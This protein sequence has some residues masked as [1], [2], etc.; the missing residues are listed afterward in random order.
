MRSA[1]EYIKYALHAVAAMRTRAF[2]VF[3]ANTIA[4]GSVIVLSSIGEG[5]RAFVVN[6]F[7]AL[8]TNLLIV[9][10]GR[11]ETSGEGLNM[12]MGSTPRD[13]TLEDAEAIARHPAVTQIAPMTVGTTTVSWRS[14]E[15]DVPIIGS[16]S[17]LSSIRNWNVRIGE[18]LPQQSD[19]QAV[20]IAVLGAKTK[21]ELF[22][23]ESAL[24]QW[25]RVGDRRFRV[26]GVLEPIGRS[27]GVDVDD[28]VIV[29][30]RS[31]QALFN[32]TSL[33]RVL[34]EA[35][36]AEDLDRVNKHILQ[37]IETRHYGEIDVTV[38]T[39]DAVMGTFTRIF[40]IVTWAVIGIA[41]ISL[42]VAGMLIMNIMFVAVTQRRAE[43]GIIMAIG[44]RGSQIMAVFLV[45]AA[46][47]AGFG[48]LLGWAVGEGAARLLSQFV[49]QMDFFVP[50]WAPLAAGGVALVT[51]L[52][53]S[54]LPAYRATQISPI[55]ALKK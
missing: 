3:L 41:S 47:L 19:G 45:E 43:I 38:I 20:S 42:V 6:E 53:F 10:P 22:G 12:F 48:A 13:L 23:N 33:F 11:T 40:D 24:G 30:V 2:L 29:P 54:L 18:F 15:R 37:V 1:L 7:A 27:I 26:V 32:I 25:L 21:Q 46:L 16:T 5:L 39:Q 31:A 51:A 34:V 49:P 14:R 50:Y 17:A 55:A 44:G 35:R 28:V 9:L 4:V 36:R 52:V 8:G